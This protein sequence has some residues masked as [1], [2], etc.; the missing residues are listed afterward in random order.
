[1]FSRDK[2]KKLKINAKF[3]PQLLKAN[4]LFSS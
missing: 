1:M 2:E 4:I 3:N